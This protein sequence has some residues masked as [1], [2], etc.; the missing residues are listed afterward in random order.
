MSKYFV[1]NLS[2][3]RRFPFLCF[4]FLHTYN[5]MCFFVCLQAKY[6]KTSFTFS[7]YS[8]RLSAAPKYIHSNVLSHSRAYSLQTNTMLVEIFMNSCFVTLSLCLLCS[9][10]DF[11]KRFFYTFFFSFQ[12]KFPVV[13]YY[14]TASFTL[15]ASSM[16]FAMV[17]NKND[18]R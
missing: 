11:R 9:F 8:K 17:R 3:R 2:F 18:G 16:G 7:S 13:F 6:P 10:R 5:I 12:N 14:F 4:F 1:C 15:V